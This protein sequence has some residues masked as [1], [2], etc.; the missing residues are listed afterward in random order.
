MKGNNMIGTE[1]SG[2]NYRPTREKISEAKSLFF[3]SLTKFPYFS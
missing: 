2:I 1:I 3:K